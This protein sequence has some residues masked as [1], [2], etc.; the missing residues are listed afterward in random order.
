MLVQDFRSNP[1]FPSQC[2]YIFF[3]A[4]EFR[5]AQLRNPLSF[6]KKI[7][8]HDDLKTKFSCS[9]ILSLPS[10]LHRTSG[11]CPYKRQWSPLIKVIMSSAEVAFCQG[12]EKKM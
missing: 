7:V 5:N 9:S 1:I 4:M 12:C 11:T 8:K 3:H 6:K 10:S 2:T